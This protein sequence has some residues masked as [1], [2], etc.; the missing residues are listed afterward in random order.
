MSSQAPQFGP[1]ALGRVLAENRIARVQAALHVSANRPVTILWLSADAAPQLSE[2]QTAASAFA[3][4]HSTGSRSGSPY[5]I[6]DP[7]DPGSLAQLGEVLQRVQDHPSG[8]HPTV[9]QA[10]QRP[11]VT[12]E[13]RR[14]GHYTVL[15]ELG[16]GGMGIVFKALDVDAN[17][18]VALKL[19]S[20]TATPSKTFLERFQRE[21]QIAAAL[22]HPGIVAVH[23]AGEHEGEP[24]L[25]YEL[26]EGARTLS[27]R[28]SDEDDRLERV[29][30]VRDAAEALGYAHAQSIV[31]RDVKPDNILVD[32]EGQVKVADFG[33]ATAVD[34]DRLTRT[35]AYVGTPTHM[36]PEQ[37]R[38]K[39]SPASDVWSLGVV[40]YEALT[41]RLPF[42]GTQIHEVVGAIMLSDPTP[43]RDLDSKIEA[44]LE[45]ICL[46]ALERDPADR[47]PDGSAMAKDLE[48]A[49]AGDATNA[50]ST[51]SSPLARK[52]KRMRRRVPRGAVAAA[53]LVV[54]VLGVG[55]AITNRAL[56]PPTE[57]ELLVL[58]ASVASG[59]S[60][61]EELEAALLESKG[62]TPATLAQLHLALSTGSATNTPGWKARLDH[63]LGALESGSLTPGERVEALL[64]K[65]LAT[66]S[67]GR[68][69]DSQTI[70]D[71]ALTLAKA[72]PKRLRDHV[73]SLQRA[74]DAN[75][76]YALRK[77]GNAYSSGHG[78]K[79]DEERALAIY[80][81]AAEL[82]DLGSVN[83][84]G[85]AYVRGAGTAKDLAKGAAWYL[86]SAEGG[87]PTAMR[88][89][90]NCYETGE[91]VKRDRAK[92][93][94]WHRRAAEAGDVDSKAE[95]GYL[96][97][98]A[99]GPLKDE[100]EGRSWIRRAAHDGNA[101]AMANLAILYRNGTGVEKDPKRA[102]E[103]AR[104]GA[105][106][107]E[108]LSL[109]VLGDLYAKGEGVV[110]DEA[111][112]LACFQTLID[113]GDLEGWL[114]LSELHQAKKEWRRALDC[115][116]EAATRGNATAMLLASGYHLQALGVPYNR[117]AGVAW[118]QK[119]VDIG[120]AEAMVTLGL[121]C[122]EGSIGPD[123]G[124][125][126]AVALFRRAADAGDDQGVV[127][128]AR[129]LVKGV[130]VERD[131]PEAL[132]LYRQATKAGNAFAMIEVGKLYEAGENVPRDMSEALFWF[133]KAADAREAKGYWNMGRVLNNGIHGIAKDLPAAVA[134]FREGA[135][136]FDLDCMFQLARMLKAGWGVPAP[137]P[138]EAFELFLKGAEFNH[139]S[140]MMKVAECYSFG[141]GTKRDR[142]QRAHWLL[143]AAQAGKTEGMRLIAQTFLTGD[144][145]EKSPQKAKEWYVQASNSGNV[146]AVRDLA[147]AYRAGRFGDRDPAAAL[148]WYDKGRAQSDTLSTLRGGDVHALDLLDGLQAK[149]WF[150]QARDQALAQK[151]KLG[152]AALVQRANARLA[153]LHMGWPGVER[154]E[155]R[156]LELY[157]DVAKAKSREGML[158]LAWLHESGRAG[159][160]RSSEQALALY[161]RV[162]GATHGAFEL[163]LG[164]GGTLN[165]GDLTL[166]PKQ[167]RVAS[168]TERGRK[169]GLKAG[170]LIQRVDAGTVEDGEELLA[171]LG[172]KKPGDF[173]RL[174]IRRTAPP[175][176][177]ALAR[178]ESPT[179]T[180]TLDK[181][182]AQRQQLGR[183][184][185]TLSFNVT[186]VVQ[187]ASP[188]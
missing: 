162:L 30:L 184:L 53:G 143:K 119:A 8:F 155:A 40:L 151:D 104:R 58:S 78:V 147:G 31:H 124:P 4:V 183:R 6:L 90:A 102:F 182:P 159:V 118:L 175:I 153:S 142:A 126:H 166:L 67:L 24:Y 63:A 59:E 105:D 19:V 185:T 68:G 54:L 2:L 84:I 18:V 87:F 188:D 123:H 149:L 42:D 73:A 43:P 106:Q 60:G 108:V 49:L 32:L 14:I 61:R 71:A 165:S 29:A 22:D 133:K 128:L 161:A 167:L 163:H 122:V 69:E 85:Y 139:A 10:D 96:L 116:E 110:A 113:N 50:D 66:Y 177:L 115:I 3:T 114:A 125:K 98:S 56:A 179:Y 51:A 140:A 75:H 17:R 164:L 79:Q 94:S 33:L 97:I 74:S 136:V 57:E 5:L 121:Y 187:I 171:T 81:R 141:Q 160:N 117:E 35:G 88:N 45:A 34:L 180:A 11:A 181:A 7:L 152:Q 103:W 99:N 64:S 23:S 12:E 107:G 156:A 176:P 37:F 28:F 52:L 89:L 134:W 168:L 95:L 93:M 55:L 137:A 178:A 9:P 127:Y 72:E 174:V 130:G 101:R 76:P 1:Y 44:N 169:A 80:K 138:R 186:I 146:A 92:A 135:K 170:D 41:G 158:A 100:A 25:A 132:D 150:E 157:R 70:Y 16:R 39:I 173:V 112:A 13:A 148:K 21:G 91:G 77:L 86:Q 120:S 109:I 145:I 36:A 83:N 82:G 38:G 129:Q 15:E 172:Q 27:E 48:R 20:S 47:Y 65:A 62:L 131:V 154:D 46:V 26:V 144:G 111:Q